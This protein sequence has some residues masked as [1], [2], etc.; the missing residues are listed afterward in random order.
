VKIRVC[1]C[2]ER[3]VKKAYERQSQFD[4][5]QHCDRDCKNKYH[6][7]SPRERGFGFEAPADKS[8]HRVGVGMLSY[9]YN[10]PV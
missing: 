10:R 8:Q 5:R 7:G 6:Q 3:L 9:L 2:G 4:N 1:P